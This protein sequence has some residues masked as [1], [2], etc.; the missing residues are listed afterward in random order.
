MLWYSKTILSR[1][2]LRGH[3][4]LFCKYIKPVN[5]EGPNI[6]TPNRLKNNIVAITKGTHC[7]FSSSFR[8][9]S[10]LFSATTDAWCVYISYYVND[11]L[12][13]VCK[14][15][16]VYWAH[17]NK[18]QYCGWPKWNCPFFMPSMQMTNEMYFSVGPSTMRRIFCEDP[19]V[20]IEKTV[21]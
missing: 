21:N 9:H 2:L 18:S 3:N 17:K 15:P 6:T 14:Y 19:P 12:M 13:C 10:I 16:L 8:L 7:P 4:T 1:L 11:W 5:M 20:L